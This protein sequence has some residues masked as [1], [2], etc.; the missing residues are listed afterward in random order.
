G[1]SEENTAVTAAIPEPNSAHSPPS[2]APSSRSAC[3]EVGLSARVQARPCLR[4]QGQMFHQVMP[5]FTRRAA[6]PAVARAGPLSAAGLGWVSLMNAQASMNGTGRPMSHPATRMDLR[7]YRPVTAPP[8][9]LVV[10]LV[11]PETTTKNEMA[12]AP[13]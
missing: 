2:S 13:R 11:K 4:G 5:P 7:V 1:S 10:A 8:S 9:A 12:I 3:S 6:S